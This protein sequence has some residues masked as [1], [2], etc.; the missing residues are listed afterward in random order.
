M[1]R[2]TIKEL[3]NDLR[4]GYAWPGG[5]EIVY[6]SDDGEIICQDCIRANFRLVVDSMRHNIQD[7][8]GIIGSAIEAVDAEST[9]ELAGDDYIQNCA[10]CNREFGE[11]S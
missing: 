7:G 3:K 6:F 4:Q 11:L 10:H 8:W 2:Y 1:K 9:R 5:Y